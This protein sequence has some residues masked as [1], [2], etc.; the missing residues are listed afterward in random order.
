MASDQ[1]SK[2]VAI[3]ALP[4]VRQTDV[5]LI[6]G[7]QYRIVQIQDKFDACPPCLYLSLAESKIVYKDVRAD[8][9]STAG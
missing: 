1:V 2:L 8:E 4:G 9:N 6:G 5:I 3:S 7:A